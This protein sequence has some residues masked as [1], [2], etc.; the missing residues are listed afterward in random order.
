MRFDKLEASA[1]VGDVREPLTSARG[2]C[3]D[4]RPQEARASD[5]GQAFGGAGFRHGPSAPMSAFAGSGPQ[6]PG[7]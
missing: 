4:G 6:V 7:S 2:L 1:H 5:V 3:A